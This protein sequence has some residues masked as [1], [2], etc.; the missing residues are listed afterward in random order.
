MVASMPQQSNSLLEKAAKHLLFAG[1]EIATFNGLICNTC[2]VFAPQSLQGL[3]AVLLIQ[4]LDP[5]S[6]YA[7]S[8]ELGKLATSSDTHDKRAH[9]DKKKTTKVVRL[10]NIV[11]LLPGI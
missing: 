11:Q 9:E 4:G 1:A 10:I 7:R 8:Q 6:Q 2:I 5:S 3:P